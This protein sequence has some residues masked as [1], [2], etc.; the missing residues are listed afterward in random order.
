[1]TEERSPLLVLGA[2]GHCRAVLAVLRHHPEWAVAGILDRVDTTRGERIDT[3]EI[4]GSFERLEAMAR[5]GMKGVALALGDGAERAAVLEKALGLGLAAPVLRH[6]SAIIDCGAEAQP[7]SLLCAGAI[8]G[9]FARLGRGAILNTGAIL[10]HE[11][12]LGAFSHACPGVRVAGRVNIGDHSVIGIGASIIDRLT[13]G[14]RVSIGA[15]A[16][17]ITNVPDGAVAVGVPARIIRYAD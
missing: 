5:L 11:S 6:G 16:V 9:P 4:L 8:L 7:G 13:I 17:V 15:G 3:V 1:M 12:H 14:S 2:G 10:D